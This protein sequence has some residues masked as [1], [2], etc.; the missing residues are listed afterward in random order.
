VA[1]RILCLV[2]V[3][4]CFHPVSAAAD[5]F[6]SPYLG[7][8]F[9]SDT[10]VREQ[11]ADRN[12]VTF[13]SSVGLLTDRVVGVEADV[14]FVPGFFQRGL[15]SSGLVMTM[16]GN[17]IVAT[18]LGVAQYGLRPYFIGGVGLLHARVASTLVGT[19][20]STFFGMNVGGGAIGPLTRRTSVR[21]D[22]RY[23]KNLS[24]DEDAEDIAGNPA[25]LGF[26]RA[27]VGL[28]FRF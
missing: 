22:V 6:V 18:P 5:G 11:A 24:H 4:A 28:S 20:N 8:R 14:G 12:K 1:R 2:F 23:F 9:A 21:F 27:T 25:D 7:V 19:P 10:T 17:V 16:M 26:W 13:G 3:G 15:T